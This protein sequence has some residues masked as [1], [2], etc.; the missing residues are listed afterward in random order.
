MAPYYLQVLRVA[1]LT[2]QKACMYGPQKS[3]EHN[4]FNITTLL[5]FY[6]LTQTMMDKVLNI[7]VPP[8]SLIMLLF[9]LPL[10]LLFNIPREI[11]GKVVLNA[12]A[13]SSI[14][15]VFIILIITKALTLM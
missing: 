7:L 10:Y 6:C 12:G 13:T 1:S 15:E 2:M 4:F 14:V 11:A 9:F 3:E 5:F 8:I